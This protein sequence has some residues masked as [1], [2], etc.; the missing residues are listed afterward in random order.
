MRREPKQLCLHC[1]PYPNDSR[2]LSE[3]MDLFFSPILFLLS[4]IEY[5]L[6]KFPRLS[7]LA[8]A[9]IAGGL[10]Q[11]LLAVKLLR[12]TETLDDDEG[13]YNR[14][15]VIVRE[16]RKRGVK[17]KTYKL[18]GNHTNYFSIE[19]NGRKKIFE[20]LP[21]W[22]I[23][24]NPTVNFDDKGKMKK[25]LE[26]ADL[27]HPQ[28]RAFRK[29]KP[30][31]AYAKHVLGFPVVIKPKNGSLS[32]HTTCNIQDEVELK[33]AIRIAQILSP[34]FIVEKFIPGDVHRVTVVDGEVV[35]SCIREAPNVVGDGQR[36]IQE[37]IDIK[38]QDPIRGSKN[39]KNF[40]LHHIAV[41]ER[42]R[43]LLTEQ[44]LNLE[45]IPAAGQKVCLHDK[46]I[47]ACGADI[48]DTTD[49]IHPENII[50]FKKVYELCGTPLIG[51]DFICQDISKSHHEQQC[52]VLEVNGLPYIDMHHYPVTGSPRNVAGA[53]LDY[54]V[55]NN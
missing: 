16:A 1:D 5:L 44:N 43:L 51:L 46:V 37:L 7:R 14:T 24:Y 21:H 42:S 17:I 22:T 49:D 26:K 29:I 52:A 50:L 2:H 32:M 47:L 19:I 12:E 31:V 6:Q 8:N 25:L 36:T 38:N 9:T 54:F 53:L 3:K 55:A 4:P 41:S 39:K 35:A 10:F 27:P 45:S 28:G 20:G 30:A 40:T 18:L 48:H 34:H 15:L 33:E 13:V 23:D 11:I